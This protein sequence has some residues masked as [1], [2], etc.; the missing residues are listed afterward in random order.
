MILVVEL[1]KRQIEQ[2]HGH[3]FMHEEVFEFLIEIMKL[4]NL[5]GCFLCW[6]WASTSN[7]LFMRKANE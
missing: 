2:Y 4:L 1:K 5:L 3:Q 7:E 6:H